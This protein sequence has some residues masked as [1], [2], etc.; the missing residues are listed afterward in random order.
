MASRLRL[1]LFILGLALVPSA[2]HAQYTL[3]SASY[4]FAPGM[5]TSSLM[6][7]PPATGA[8]AG[9]PFYL[10]FQMVNNGSN[11][12][13][14]TTL[15][16]FTFGA[17][18]SAVGNPVLVNGGFWNGQSLNGSGSA[19]IDTTG[20]GQGLIQ[21]FI[22]GDKLNFQWVVS[23]WIDSI[24][25]QP[26]DDTPSPDEFVFYILYTDPAGFNIDEI[27]DGN[28]NN[29]LGLGNPTVNFIPTDDFAFGNVAF[30]RYRFND[31]AQTFSAGQP[32]DTFP[33]DGKLDT[34]VPF[35]INGIPI[36]ISAPFVVPEP[37]A[38]L[39]WTLM[40]G[41]AFGFVHYRRRQKPE[42]VAVPA[43]E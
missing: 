19:T 42:L 43:T 13:N 35:F 27:D 3:G 16:N 25:K 41:M 10:L 17:G 6:S 8:T 20:S 31:D 15:N 14:S 37:S 1:S 29:S 26:V 30:L 7:V 22:P 23:R 21:Q 32:V 33:F 36:T 9:S 34:I 11:F 39:V 28:N 4:K 38:I 2:A 12:T 5:D 24:T 18:G 40:G